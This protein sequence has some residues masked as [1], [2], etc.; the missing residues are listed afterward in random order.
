MFT[1]VTFLVAVINGV[2][3]NQL[4]PLDPDVE[5]NVVRVTLYSSLFKRPETLK[6]SVLKCVN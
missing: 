3:V 4:P 2:L 6:N 5:R 1:R